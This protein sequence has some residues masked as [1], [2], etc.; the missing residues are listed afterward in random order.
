MRKLLCALIET[1]V[2]IGLDDLSVGQVV[3]DSNTFFTRDGD[4][5]QD[6]TNE[7]MSAWS[8]ML[9]F[10]FSLTDN[11][12]VDHFSLPSDPGVLGRLVA[13]LGRARSHCP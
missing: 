3:D 1:V 9:C 12:G 11:P 4:V 8:A 13:D 10:S 7:A 5:N 2:G 6:L